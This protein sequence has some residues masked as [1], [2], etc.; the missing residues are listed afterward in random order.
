MHRSPLKHQYSEP[1]TREVH[2]FN[3]P[4]KSVKLFEIEGDTALEHAIRDGS[5]P[6]V[7]EMLAAEKAYAAAADLAVDTNFLIDPAPF[8]KAAACEVWIART[9]NGNLTTEEKNG[10]MRL[11]I[12]HIERAKEI[13]IEDTTATEADLLPIIVVEADIAATRGLP[14]QAIQTLEGAMEFLDGPT[15]EVI[16]ELAE[17][18]RHDGKMPISAEAGYLLAA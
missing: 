17:S 5:E 14:G 15:P 10:L 2:G 3:T 7:E 18:L 1:V 9:S 11:A 6:S 4:P 16:G 13:L 12:V 8:A